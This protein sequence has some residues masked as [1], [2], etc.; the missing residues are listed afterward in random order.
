[1]YT[2]AGT[3][4]DL[5]HRARQK[6]CGLTAKETQGNGTISV[7]NVGAIGDG[8]FAAPV[9]VPSGGIAIVA[10]GRAHWI[11]DVSP[12]IN[13]GNGGKRLKIGVSWSADHRVVEG[14]EMAAF[15]E[16]WRGYVESPERMIA[17]GV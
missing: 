16:T 4:A 9:L 14:A 1:M 3:L 7:S 12:H 8:H 2:L 13:N 11:W 17:E 15:C 5:S 6:P 10:I